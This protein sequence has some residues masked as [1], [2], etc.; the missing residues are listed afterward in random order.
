MT[1]PHHAAARL[2]TDDEQSALET[3]PTDLHIGRSWTGHT[4]EDAC[5]C[6]KAPCGLV[7]MTLVD[8]DCDQHPWSR[9]KS[10]RQS[11]RPADCPGGAS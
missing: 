6:G 3:I 8:P 10:I 7:D 4:L 2:R 11:H 5:P 1:E 9:T